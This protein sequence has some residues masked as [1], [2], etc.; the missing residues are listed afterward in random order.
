MVKRRSDIDRKE[1]DRDVINLTKLGVTIHKKLVLSVVKKHR[2]KADAIMYLYHLK[3]SGY[4][5][6]YMHKFYSK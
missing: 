6:S 1:N 2:K 4:S 5:A 3:N